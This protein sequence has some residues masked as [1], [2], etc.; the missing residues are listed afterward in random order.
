MIT[1]DVL[2]I[3][4]GISGLTIANELHKQGKTILCVE[5]ARGSGGRLSSKRVILP[6]GEVSFDLGCSAFTARTPRFKHKVNEWCEAGVLQTWTQLND[7]HWYVGQ[8][9]S[10]SITRH[11]AD[12][13]AVQFSTRITRLEKHRGHWAVYI[14]DNN[15][16]HCYALVDD[17]IITA[18]APQCCDLLPKDHLLRYRIKKVTVSAQWVVMLALREALNMED[19]WVS[20]SLNIARVSYENS[21]P[22]RHQGAGLHVYTI[23]A[24]HEWSDS[25]TDY[26]KDK[27]LM[28]LT[29]EFAQLTQQPLHIEADYCHRWLY[30][31]GNQN[32]YE[33]SGFLSADDGIH[34]CADYLAQDILIDG[35][36]AAYL[37]ALAL[38]D[39][40][41]LAADHRMSS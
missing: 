37:S 15:S 9:R 19:F 38:A 6:D 17:V 5:K 4:A 30:A 24:S 32:G 11:L 41:M 36:E 31:Q 8:S 3:G 12:S 34:I 29:N 10:S 33:A 18:P 16:E 35:V 7:E 27:V 28:E 21:K 20:P 40:L 23:Q 13:L 2:V 26:S 22:N 25:R 39:H 14:E 1:A